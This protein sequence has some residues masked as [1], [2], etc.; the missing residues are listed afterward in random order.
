MHSKQQGFTLIEL[1]IV[2]AIVGILATIAIPAYQDYAIRAKMGE[3]LA[4]M[5][6]DKAVLSE[7]YM[8]KGFWPAETSLDSD[9]ELS[10]FGLSVPMASSSFLNALQV[11]G[12]PNPQVIYT[13]SPSATL[14]NRKVIMEAIII[15]GV[16]MDWVCKSATLDGLDHKYLPPTCR[17]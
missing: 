10:D 2:V 8:S 12:P 3:V 14:I 13:I 5:S 9:T 11:L 7:F 15:D 6:R 17:N 4:M 16:I 1:M